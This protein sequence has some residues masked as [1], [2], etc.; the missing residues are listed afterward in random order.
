MASAA[1]TQRLNQA[2]LARTLGVSRQAIG[3]LIK[4]QIIPIS[5]DGLID[6]ELAK[7]AIANRVRPSGKT[8]AATQQ[9]EQQPAQIN[10][11]TQAQ[12]ADA[13]MSYHV[14]KTLREAAE[15]RIAQLR[16]AEL[17]GQLVRASAVRQTLARR[18]AGLREALL[19]LPARVVPILAANPD[20]ASM[21]KA[22]R[23][24]IVAALQQLV[25]E[26]E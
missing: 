26:A 7:H 20:P 5:G 9:P 19:Q 12:A 10:M 23:A 25:D 21:D 22:L 17:Q 16:L 18:A 14:A 13:L 24:E 15:A 4:R 11:P 1:A 3:D 8:A 6:V 2:S